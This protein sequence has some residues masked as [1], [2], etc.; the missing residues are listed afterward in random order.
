MDKLK[1]HTPNLA[2]ENFRK[3]SA[4]FPNAV[5]ETIDE[6]GKVVRAIDADVLRQETAVYVV[7]GREERYQFTWPDKRKAILT[8]NAPISKTLRPCREESVGRDGTPGGFDSENIY[9]EGDNLEVLKLLQET[10]LGKIKMIYI[11]PPYNTGSDFIYRD[12]FARSAGQYIAH[13]GQYDDEGN[14]LV[15][16]TE[17]NGRFHTDWLNM[18]YP[19]LKLAKNLLSDNGSIFVSIDFN[20]VENLKKIMDEIFGPDNFQREIIWRIGWLSG[21]KTTAP[22]FIR[23]HDTIL[24]YSKNQEQLEFFKKYIMNADFK[25]L[26]DQ[27]AKLK[28]KLDSLGL[29]AG[30]QKELLQFLNY[31]NRPEKYPIEDTWNANEYDDLNSIAIVSFSGEKISKILDIDQDFKGQKAVKMLMRIIESTTKDDDI[32]MDFF[33]GTASTAHAVFLQNLKDGC[34][35]RNIMVQYPELCGEAGEEQDSYKNICEVGKERIRRVGAK[36]KSD[37]PSA[38]QDLDIGFRVLKCDESNMKPVYYTPADTGQ[39]QM[40]LLADNIKEDRT[41]EDLLFQVMLDMGISLSSTIVTAEI[42]GKK[43]FDVGGNFLLAC[44]DKDVT[45]ETVTEAAKRRPL[46]FAMRDSS[47]ADDTVAANFE[48]IFRTYSP[49][50]VRRVL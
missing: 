39:D 30:Q 9:I 45:Q 12:D 11:D 31:D 28:D 40:D 2:D 15:Q 1:M 18:M 5:T 8:A 13:S 46:Y 6:E 16:N 29:D 37:N 49:D 25:P 10:Y 19:R 47:M 24:F 48:Q 3:L 4:L 21:Y 23:N 44:F 36:I 27:S 50:T 42:A 32:V 38:I 20:E 35:R 14:L 7:E 34:H 26:I 43:V 41:P 22:N 17:R 33:S